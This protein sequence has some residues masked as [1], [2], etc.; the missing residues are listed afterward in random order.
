MTVNATNSAA[1]TEIDHSFQSSYGTVPAE[2]TRLFAT[3]TPTTVAQFPNEEEL[4]SQVLEAELMS[5][6]SEVN[7]M[8]RDGSLH[9]TVNAFVFWSTRAVKYPR[10]YRM[11]MKYLVI[12]PTSVECERMFS[13]SGMTDSAL[14]SRLLNEHLELLVFLKQNM[15]SEQTLRRMLN[16]VLTKSRKRD[17][18]S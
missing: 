18:P 13:V 7:K 9:P 10:L 5:Y 3:A 1:A 4:H 12:P 14:R 17:A 15:N 2:F 11:A 8:L 16:S 6:M